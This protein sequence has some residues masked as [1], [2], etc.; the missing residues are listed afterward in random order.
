MKKLLSSFFHTFFRK[1]LELRVKVFHVLAITGFFICIATTIISILQEMT[2][3]AVINAGTGI[4]SLFLML[5]SAK[6][7][8]PSICYIG[9]VICIFLILFPSLFIFGG[10]Y[11]GGMAFFFVFAV[12]YTV[13]M[14][15]GWKKVVVTLFELI[16]YTGF[17][18]FAF[19]YPQYIQPFA[20]EADVV[21][22]VIFGFVVVSISLGATFFIQFR[23]YNQQQKELQQA[24]EEAEIANSAKTNF[25][26]NMSHEIRTPIH[27]IMSINEMISMETSNIRIKEYVDKIRNAGDVLRALVDNILD[28]SKIEAGRTEI[29]ASPYRTAELMQVLELTGQTRCNAKHLQFRCIQQNLPPVLNGDLPHIRQIAINLLSNAVKYT[30]SGSVTL[31]VTGKADNN[32]EQ[33]LL[34]IAV[35]DTGIGIEEKAVPKLFDAFSRGDMLS[36][37][38]IEGTGLGLAIV[39]DLCTLM[40]GTIHVESRAG[41]G[42]TF[43][44]EIPQMNAPANAADDKTESKSFIA[45][46]GRV[47]VVDDNNENLAVMRELLR[48]TQLQVD[49]VNSG[50]AALEAVSKKQYHIVLLDYMMPEMDG[51]A[52]MEQFKTIPGFSAPVIALTANALTGIRETMLQIGFSEYL[53]KP[54][55][56]ERLQ[57]MLIEFLPDELVTV[58]QLQTVSS[59]QAEQFCSEFCV[60]LQAYHID[61]HEALPYFDGDPRKYLQTANIF[62][63]HTE[64]DL[65]KLQ[66]LEEKGNCAELVFFVHSLKGRAR[67]LGFFSLAE[68]AEHMEKLCKSE[69]AEEAQYL[70]PHLRFLYLKT[71]EGIALLRPCMEEQHLDVENRIICSGAE[72]CDLLP[73]FLKQYRRKEALECICVLLEEN[74]SENEQ[75]LL[76]AMRNAISE[77]QF[78]QALAIYE[79]Y[80]VITAGKRR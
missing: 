33:T 3:S 58:T 28:M 18:I 36:H 78:E 9:T 68:E 39:K 52:T 53:T 79:K 5:Y 23:L 45:P 67:N 38:Y 77:I 60:P 24:R 42:S 29:N 1:E 50:K 4:L 2:I 13:Y 75:T 41:E 12:V 43:I 69:E 55:P 35:S 47:L 26:A 57:A 64:H 61:L 54:I 73:I 8:K 19:L 16:Y 25:L 32:S 44:A 22:D 15:D 11:T 51:I 74:P 56:W 71:V 46:L 27:V 59:K 17:C 62:M 20:S 49:T 65:K 37:K 40:G 70:I 7:G 31:T 21:F 48:R 34:S 80:S 30:E 66:V 72:C 14:L 6:G 63:E 10:G 76:Q